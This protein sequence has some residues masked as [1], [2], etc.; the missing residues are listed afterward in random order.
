MTRKTVKSNGKSYHYYY[1]PTP[2]SRCH[3]VGMIPEKQLEDLVL[4]EIQKHV[5]DVKALLAQIPHQQIA[6]GF[7][8]ELASKLADNEEEIRRT[9]R[10]QMSLRDNLAAK[11]IDEA[12][13]Q[14]LLN[15]YEAEL[16][17]LHQESKSIQQKSIFNNCSM[18][19]DNAW[20]DSFLSY[21]NLSALARKT[22]LLM[23]EQLHLLS[24]A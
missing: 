9:F 20:K 12:E 4:Q 19:F 2:K 18:P 21:A 15:F 24:K 8:R 6:R 17:R 14:V 22:V 5:E 23:V 1:C 11:V 13:Y 16:C 3:F 10:F 7:R